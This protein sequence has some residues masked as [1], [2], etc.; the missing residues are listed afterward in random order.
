MERK[1]Y[2]NEIQ[3]QLGLL[4]RVR[5][6]V[7][8]HHAVDREVQ[9]QRL[10]NLGSGVLPGGGDQFHQRC[11]VDQGLCLVTQ[12]WC[13][14]GLWVEHHDMQG[15]AWHFG[16]LQSGLNLSWQLAHI[17]CGGRLLGWG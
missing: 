1:G 4:D 3:Q 8:A 10:A 11:R 9:R 5:R 12:A 17:A 2:Q 13:G 7:L 15:L 16:L 6:I 14:G